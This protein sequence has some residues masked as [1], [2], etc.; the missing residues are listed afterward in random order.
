MLQAARC[1]VCSATAAQ[2][3]LGLSPLAAAS[4]AAA[5]A[6]AGRAEGAASGAAAAD[7]SALAGAL[8]SLLHRCSSG[9]NGSPRSKGAASAHLRLR[10]PVFHS[11]GCLHSYANTNRSCS[12]SSSSCNSQ[13][14]S[15]SD[16]VDRGSTSRDSSSSSSKSGASSSSSSSGS[17]SNGRSTPVLCL[18]IAAVRGFLAYSLLEGRSLRALRFG[19]FDWSL[20]RKGDAEV[21]LAAKTQQLMQVLT[22]LQQQQQE[23]RLRESSSSSSSSSSSGDIKWL[24]GFQAAVRLP[25]S[26][27]D[28][29]RQ[30][31]QQ[32]LLGS[33]SVGLTSAFRLKKI[34]YIEPQAARHLLGARL[35]RPL[36][37]REDLHKLLSEAVRMRRETKR[38]TH[39]LRQQQR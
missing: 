15:S 14:D 8:F 9:T 19:L 18:G 31:Q 17:S 22:Q 33:V 23:E 3:P 6:A 4:A 35:G 10:R 29:K 16:G 28:L 2:G 27:A 30:Q 12:N 39:R 20:L 36:A 26:V 1:C 34:H 5:A 11:T 38:H 13:S 24:V 7:A 37:S 25:R 32:Q 21:S